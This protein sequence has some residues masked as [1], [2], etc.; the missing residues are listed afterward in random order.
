[1]NRTRKYP[2]RSRRG[3][4]MVEMVIATAMFAA[5][6][7]YI[8]STFTG[9]T[10]STQNATVAIDLGSQNK[11]A[12]TKVYNELQATSVIEQ[13][14]DGV[15]STPPE[16]VFSITEDT[17]APRPFTA[18]SPRIRARRG[19]SR[20]PGWSSAGRFPRHRRAKP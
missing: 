8:Y 5:G 14:T 3:F 19:R 17:G 12:L 11:K 13:D 2:M 16:A 4:T 1:M 9:V 10:R 6:S 20:R 15:D 7:L 18:R